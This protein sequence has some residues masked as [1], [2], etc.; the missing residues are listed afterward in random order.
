MITQ[1][2][3]NGELP[4]VQIENEAA[5]ASIC[6]LG[7]TIM[8]YQPKGA[9]PVLWTSPNSEYK[10]GAPIRGGIPVCWPWFGPHPTDPSLPAH[11]FVRTRLWRVAQAVDETPRRSV[12]ELV[13]E[14]DEA[15]RQMWP[16]AFSLSLRVT[17][18]A[19]LSAALISTNRG[20]S[21]FPFSTAL[22]TYFA[23][24]DISSIA[25]DGLDNV[26]FLS[27]VHDYARF[28]E[29]GT[30]HITQR[31]DRVYLDTTSTCTIHD[32]AWNRQIVVEKEGSH[33]TVVWNAGEKIS[34]EMADLGAGMYRQYVCVETV[35]GPQEHKVLP[36]GE[37]H[38]MIAR[39][40]LK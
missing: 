4:F 20:S 3:G 16:H 26:P 31:E 12:V 2:E 30:L 22:H 24:S 7:A 18:G 1:Q 40:Y 11:G 21:E 35:I 34:A 23:I 13:C 8:D 10:V 19:E 39:I 9:Q 25:I 14:D 37:T 29:P 17:V 33:T 36:A 6:L 28:V 27:K 32:P 15:T 38:A 5:R